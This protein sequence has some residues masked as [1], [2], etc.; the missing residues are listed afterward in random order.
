MRLKYYVYHILHMHIHTGMLYVYFLLPRV[1][2]IHFIWILIISICSLLYLCFLNPYFT[3]ALQYLTLFHTVIWSIKPTQTFTYYIIWPKILQVSML[4][5][6]MLAFI[7]LGWL[8]EPIMAWPPSQARPFRCVSVWSPAAVR[9]GSK[10]KLIAAE[11]CN[12]MAVKKQHYS[13]ILSATLQSSA[14]KF[15]CGLHAEWAILVECS[16]GATV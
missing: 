4:S 10:W 14:A 13:S 2:Q 15:G 16:R 9:M 5:Q 8:Q 7:V 3:N 11:A 1:L 6:V 12:I